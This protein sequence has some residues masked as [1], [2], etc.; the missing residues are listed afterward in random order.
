[1]ELTDSHL[2]LW[3]PSRARYGWFDGNADLDR[4]FLPGDIPESSPTATIF[5]E[6]G[7]PDGL[8]EARWVDS[9]AGRWKG[10]AGIV[11]AAP[12]ELGIAVRPHLNELRSIARVVGVRRLLQDETP[13][14]FERP[15]L[16]DGLRELAAV[17]L[18]FDACVRY[19]QLPALMALLRQVPEL[20][21]VLDHL[22]KPPVASGKLD[23]WKT[24]LAVLAT[25]PTASVKLSGVSPES[26]PDLPLAP[27]ALPVVQYV[28]DLFGPDRCMVG[29]D[30][31]VSA[32]IP[33]SIGYDD[34]FT[35]IL[36]TV[37]RAGMAK[38]AVAA[39]TAAR[40]YGLPAA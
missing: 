27:Q 39:R 14:F 8:A 15:Q 19:H 33:N 1:M 40:V 12:L 21:V 7:A 9:L 31:P 17:G 10:L 24:S 32:V 18:P 25:M 36:E 30:W 11:A 6:A 20:T 38:E 26:D 29:S 22:G 2:H 5:V 13:D 35:L 16:V 28:L 23:E 4:A 3:D 37:E 34:W